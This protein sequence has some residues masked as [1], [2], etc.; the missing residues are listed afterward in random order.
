MELPTTMGNRPLRDMLHGNKRPLPWKNKPILEI[1]KTH[2][3]VNLYFAERAI[4][5]I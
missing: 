4:D 3:N 2:V 1:C 5:L